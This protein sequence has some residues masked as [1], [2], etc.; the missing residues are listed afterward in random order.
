M[1]VP[2]GQVD[3]ITKISVYDGELR[4]VGQEGTAGVSSA[5]RSRDRTRPRGVSD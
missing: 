5:F 3:D 2:G 4:Y 1:D